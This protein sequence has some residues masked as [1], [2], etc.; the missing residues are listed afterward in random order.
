MK[1]QVT[2]KALLEAYRVP[3]FKALARVD[4]YEHLPPIFVITLVRRQKKRYAVAA[5]KDSAVSMIDV[6]IALAT[7][8]VAIA[9]CIS[10]LNGAAWTAKRVAV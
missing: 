1:N 7:S 6:G 10:T 8:A 3:G 5:E 2:K 4:G 9:R